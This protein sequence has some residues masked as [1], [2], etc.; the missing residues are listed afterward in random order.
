MSVRRLNGIFAEAGSS[1]AEEIRKK[2][3]DTVASELR[4]ARFA[5]MSISEVAMK[6]GF[7]NLQHFSTAFKGAFGVSPRTYRGGEG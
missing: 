2:R 4:D 7:N 3:L 1:I 5:A 6:C